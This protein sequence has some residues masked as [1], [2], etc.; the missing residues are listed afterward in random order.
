MQDSR[1]DTYLALLPCVTLPLMTLVRQLND[2]YWV[3]EIS[4][5]LPMS[6]AQPPNHPS[7]CCSKSIIHQQ[8]RQKHYHD[9]SFRPLLSLSIGEKVMIKQR[10]YFVTIPEE[11][12]YREK[13]Q[14]ASQALFS[15][16]T[17]GL[18]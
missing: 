4:T 6:I 13:K 2:N 7:I 15:S 17:P 8:G 5:L 11:Q 16:V 9:R 18:R 10:S 14:N 12:T 3:E 1:L